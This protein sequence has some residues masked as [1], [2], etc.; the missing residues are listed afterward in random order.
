MLC[1]DQFETKQYEQKLLRSCKLMTGVEA[2]AISER[3]GAIVVT[4]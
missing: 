2:I 4:K 3:T 1:P